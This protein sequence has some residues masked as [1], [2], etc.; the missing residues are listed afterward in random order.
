MANQPKLKITVFG[1]GAM[2]SLFG[3]RLK[4]VAQVTLFGHWLAQIE[5]LQQRGLTV[6]EVDGRQTRHTLRVTNDLNEIEMADVVLI[7]VKSYQTATVA[8]HVA[9]ILGSEGVALTLQNGLGNVEQLANAVGC[10]RVALG[11]T[12]QGATLIAPGHLRHAGLGLT[13]LASDPKIATKI[14]TVAALFNESGLETT[15][16]DNANSLLWG[17]LAINAGINPLTALLEVSNGELLK[18]DAWRN[19]M[20]AAANEVAAVAIA[21]GIGLPFSDVSS[22][23]CEV[24]WATAHNRSSMLQDI[25]RQAPTEID[26]ICGEVVRYGQQAGIPTPINQTLWRLVK[27]KEAGH[28]FLSAAAVVDRLSAAV[29]KVGVTCL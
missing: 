17:K 29:D 16:V 5:A 10:E 1:V 26:A 6:A 19:L 21:Q 8:P 28:P 9:K 11:V 25:S 24:S 14:Q 15:V 4:A 18:R 7:L 22:R 2:A 13:H 20:V 23:V 3:S 12:A 27:A